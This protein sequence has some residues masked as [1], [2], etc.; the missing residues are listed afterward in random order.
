[1][2]SLV[3]NKRTIY[4]ALYLGDTEILDE[5]GYATGMYAPSY[6]EPQKLEINVSAARG[7]AWTREFG[8]FKNY[9]RTMVTTQD[10]PLDENSILWVDDLDITHPHDYQVVQ[11]AKSLNE[12]QYA[13]SK[14][15]VKKVES[16]ND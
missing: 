1:M 3:R 14:V 11:V 6:A 7:S 4:Y 10:L 15:K 5:D 8:D 13:I 2:R 16:A 9:D 12:N